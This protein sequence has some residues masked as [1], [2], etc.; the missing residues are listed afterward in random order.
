M[1]RP[2]R[3]GRP[4]GLALSLFR[5]ALDMSYI[6]SLFENF[7]SGIPIILMGRNK[8]LSYSLTYGMMDMGDYFLER[9][10][11]ER[12]ERDGKYIPLKVRKYKLVGKDV[13]FYETEEGHIIERNVDSYGKTISDGTYLALRI[14]ERNDEV[15]FRQA[16]IPFT[17]TVEEAQKLMP[18]SNLGSNYLLADTMGNIGYQQSGSV[19]LR[20]NSDGLLPLPAWNSANLWTGYLD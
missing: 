17:K 2:R 10:K 11:D 15:T 5:E 18:Q 7:F 14:P 12:Y 3:T 8:E 13:L 9:I 20:P 16:L 4:L 6:V 1:M 19:P